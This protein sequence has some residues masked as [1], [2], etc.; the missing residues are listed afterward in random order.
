MNKTIGFIPRD[1]TV[2]DRIGFINKANYYEGHVITR[3]GDIINVCAIDPWSGGPKD[4]EGISVM[5]VAEII[6]PIERRSTI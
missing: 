3:T 1:P 4:F 5:C 6:K 2:G